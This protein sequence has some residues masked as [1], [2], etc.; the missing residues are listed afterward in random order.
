MMQVYMFLLCGVATESNER[1]APGA[2]RTLLVFLKQGEE[3]A[4]TPN[5]RLCESVIRSC[6]WNLTEFKGATSA[7]PDTVRSIQKT[8]EPA[9][10]QAYQD[11]FGKGFGVLVFGD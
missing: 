8:P 3:D 10:D 6:G 11:A 1:I 9:V 2:R 4:A 5:F 7:T